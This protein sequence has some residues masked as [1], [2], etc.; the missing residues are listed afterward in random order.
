LIV[1]VV[2]SDTSPL[3]ALAQLG[4]LDLL[5]VLFGQV[6]VPPAVAQELRHP[7][8]GL[9]VID[10]AQVDFVLLQAPQNQIQVQQLLQS[11][12][13]GEAEALALAVEVQADA[14]LIDEAAGRIAAAQLGDGNRCTG[15]SVAWQAKGNDRSRDPSPGTF[16]A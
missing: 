8:G 15:R 2:V 3:R 10:I 14:V 16:R 1:A 9:P 4:L 6:L 7:P 5:Q 11:L 13:P 12:D